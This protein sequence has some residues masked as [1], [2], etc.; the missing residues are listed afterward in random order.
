VTDKTAASPADAPRKHIGD[1][2]PDMMVEELPARVLGGFPLAVFTFFTVAAICLTLNQLLNLQLF[3]GFVLIDSLY[4]YLLAAFL[5]PLVFF[6]YSGDGRPS[7]GPVPWYDWLLALA[8]F[9]TFCWFT[10]TARRALESGWEYSAPRDAII[11]SAIACVLILEGLRRTS[12]LVMTLIVVEVALYPLVADKFP[13]PLTGH[14][15]SLTETI[16]FHVISSESAFGIAYKALGEIV[17]GYIV[18][19][20]ALNYTG[21][22]KFFNDLA[23][24]LVGKMRGG[25]AQVGVISSGLQGSISGSV[26]S[27][28]ITSGV[29]TIP[30]MKRTG[31]RSDYAGGVEAVAST[32]AVLMPPVMGSTAFVMASFLNK[33]YAEIALAATIPGLLFYFALMVQIDAY[34]ARLGLRGMK[35]EELPRARDVMREGWYFIPVF[36]AL[37]IFMVQ[38]QQEALA[39]FY[40]TAILLF[41]NQVLPKHRMDFARFFEFLAATG[42]ALVELA[43]LLLGVGFLIGAL[44]MTGLAGTL[45]NDLVYLAGNTPIM[46]L[47]MG[48][49]TS[50]IFGLGLTVTACYIFLA[51]VLAPPLIKAGLDPLAIHMFVLYWGMVSFITP[52]V[53]LAAFAAAPLAKTSQ[54]KIGIQAMRLGT[55]IYVIPFCFVLNPAL[56]MQGEWKTIIPSIIFA[57]LGIG[58][59]AAALQGYVIRIGRIPSSVS[60]WIVR[61]MLLGSALY[62]TIPVERFVGLNMPQSFGFGCALAAAALLLLYQINKITMRRETA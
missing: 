15:K 44:T 55:A 8:A 9:V 12:G 19:G 35:A 27:N 11:F 61:L 24:A 28:V 52:P 14:A 18:F 42:R 43:A 25:A 33:P 53:A 7:K 34:S 59:A 22:G 10:Y 5:L 16:A 26:I 45:A 49:L 39:P 3:V 1:Q 62:L 37:L 29:V 47:V 17:V 36:I 56:L 57:F 46:L 50:F 58:I 21:G 32:G 30:A 60:G 13:A 20:V 4:L 41:I 38:E 6:A 40:A 54:T 48:A 51:I 31:F 2:A 23:F